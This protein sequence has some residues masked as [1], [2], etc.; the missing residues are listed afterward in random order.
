MLR[1]L[2]FSVLLFYSLFSGMVAA[3]EKNISARDIV[4][5]CD[6]KYPGE[7]QQSR[8]SITLKDSS[9]NERKHVYVRLW[10]DMKGQQ[11]V[12]D[13]M[14]LFTVYPPDAKGAAF[15]RWSHTRDSEKNAEQWI[16]LPVL[17]KVRKVSV[18]DL[19]D[20]FLGSDLTYGDIS[21][22]GTDDDTHQLMGID[23][24]QAGQQYYVIESRP[25]EKQPQYS[26][27]LSW[28][29]KT[30]DWEACVKA[31]V[32]YFDRK[33][34]LLKRQELTWQKKG[35]A[36]IWDKV[37][38]RNAQTFHSSLFEVSDVTINK[39]ISDKIFTERRLRLGLK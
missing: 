26:K 37:I 36:W 17:K 11:N 10:K 34:A 14:L 35:P 1:R 16:F 22:R 29:K 13:K 18:R 39:T 7:Y 9:R 31:R 21:W 33:G 23:K 28:Y 8:L 19:G 3:A 5:H 24:D 32:D 6:N 27:R 4:D 2:S 12:V 25:K 15:M 30:N 20:S 38:V